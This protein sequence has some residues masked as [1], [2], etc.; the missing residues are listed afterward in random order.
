MKKLLR[1]LNI[2]NI[3]GIAVGLALVIVIYFLSYL[4]MQNP[5]QSVHNDIL[6][7]ADNIRNYY[8][9]D[10]GYWKLDTEAAKSASLIP[11]DLLQYEDFD[12]KIGQGENGDLSM[13]YNLTFDVT[14][15]NL[16]KSAC[17]SLSEIKISREESLGL[18]KITII[19][20]N[21]TTEFVWGDEENKLPISKWKTRN[22]CQMNGNKIMWTFQ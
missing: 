16:N 21:K 6:K 15:G 3:S 11:E 2:P 14:V 18:Q 1:K 8:R 12:I 13:P 9:D 4:L 7:T 20:E 10:P 22:I 5:Y 17:I 19:T